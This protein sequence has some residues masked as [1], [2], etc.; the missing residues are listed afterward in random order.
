MTITVGN[1]KFLPL[2][3]LRFRDE[4]PISPEESFYFANVRHPA[5][6]LYNTFSL[7]GHEQN[8]AQQHPALPSGANITS[9]V[10]YES[11]HFTL[12]TIERGALSSDT[13][14]VYSAAWLLDTAWLASQGAIWRGESQPQSLLT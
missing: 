9:T 8:R 1:D 3:W 11:R 13:L 10:T 6:H 5:L 12:F 14:V 2:T 7:Q 4:L